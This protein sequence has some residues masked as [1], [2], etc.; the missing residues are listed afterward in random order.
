[1]IDDVFARS[2]DSESSSTYSL[3]F[4][5]LKQQNICSILLF[6]GLYLPPIGRYSLAKCCVAISLKMTFVSCIMHLNS[7]LYKILF[8]NLSIIDILLIRPCFRFLYI[9]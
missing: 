1:M 5:T 9:G 6:M 2:S 4:L 7:L 8:E 3:L